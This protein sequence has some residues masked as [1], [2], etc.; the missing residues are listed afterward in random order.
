[1]FSFL[2]Q[3]DLAGDL[4]RHFL[5][6][7]WSQLFVFLIVGIGLLILP[8]AWKYFDKPSDRWKFLGTFFPFALA[9]LGVVLA[10]HLLILFICWEATSLLSYFLISFK[11]EEE[12]GRR[13]AL[14]T[15]LITGAGGLCLLCAI[16][17]FGSTNGTWTLTA[18]TSQSLGSH[19]YGHWI[20]A[21]LLVAAF[22]K[23]AQFPFHFWLAGA[24]S[25]P[26]PAS[27]YLHSATMVKAGIYLLFRIHPALEGITWAF[28]LLLVVGLIT[29][30]IGAMSSILQKDLKA[31]LAGTTVSNLGLMVALTSAPFAGFQEVL[32]LT[33]LAHAIYK[34]G[35]F[36]FAGVIEHIAHSRSIERLQGLKKTYPVLAVLGLFLAGANI[37]FPFTLGYFAKEGAAWPTEWKIL[38]ILG[39]VLLGKAGLLVAVKPFWGQ[40]KGI[41]EAA[42]D[43]FPPSFWMQLGPFILAAASWFS[44]FFLTGWLIPSYS[45]S[46]QMFLSLFILILAIA[47]YQFWKPSWAEWWNTNS[48]PAGAS[49]F[50]QLWF[51]QI[52]ILGASS[53]CLQNGK[54]SFYLSIILLT[55]LLGLLSILDF[56]R[57]QFL[58]AS[59]S[60]SGLSVVGLGFITL[61]LVLST[62]L[63]I[64]SEKVLH[65]I[66]LLGLTGFSLALIFALLGAPDLALTQ[67]SVEALTVF[68]FAI[69][70]RRAANFSYEKNLAAKAFL[71]LALGA[72]LT[73]AV[74]SAA[75]TQSPS[76][77][78]GYFSENSYLLAHG[79]N[80]VN[81]ILV[82]F[83]GLDTLGE[84]TVLCLAGM[85]ILSLLERK[86]T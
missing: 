55:T 72:V 30:S 15:A 41:S 65:S 79:K 13:S 25:A 35:L 4:T 31:A 9:M 8:Y 75:Q 6:D 34:A 67:V 45:F 21:L 10:D 81:V 14:H 74:F 27:A 36:L 19:E 52:N 24:M 48:I 11:G 5:W 61:F 71:S 62:G 80:V 66:L 22:T 46:P 47:L 57:L 26:T 37:G 44:P 23:S 3:L 50:D 29:F 59:D 7:Q 70:L 83:R 54:L 38:V 73:L 78:A 76:R 39:T 33:V 1:M 56:S 85:G 2:P 17:L 43:D 16:I 60:L 68:L 58:P 64:R 12:A 84:I 53:R 82:D 49:L 28:P 63:L 32:V 40:R 18:L 77:I 51:G 20:A 69:A 42:V 86:K